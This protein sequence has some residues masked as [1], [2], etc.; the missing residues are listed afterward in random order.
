MTALFAN[1]TWLIAAV[2]LAACLWFAL[3]ELIDKR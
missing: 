1:P 3:G 2:I